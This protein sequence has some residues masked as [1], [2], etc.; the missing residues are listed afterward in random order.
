MARQ[1]TTPVQ[2]RRSIRTDQGAIMSSARAGRVVPVA[3]M[4]L[5]RG[6]SAS[7]RIGIDVELAEMPKPVL[8]AVQVHFQA[9]VVGKQALPRF[10][11]ET[12]LMH[13]YTGEP[14]KQL[15]SA[16][17]T[18]PPWFHVI[19]GVDDVAEVDAS[20]FFRTLGV[21]IGDK[22]VNTDLLDS[23][24]SVYNFRLAAHSSKLPLR[25]YAQVDLTAALELPPAFWPTS[26]LTRYVPDYER[27]LV[28]GAL[29]LDIAA[30]TIP[31]TGFVPV[32]GL[33]QTSN[34]TSGS[35]TA[36]GFD[37][38]ASD[39]SVGNSYTA[40]DPA[41]VVFKRLPGN[42]SGVAL[43]IGGDF[44]SD[45]DDN[46]AV[47]DMSG[48][49]ITSTL[50]DIDKA[51]D[52]QAFARLRS[53]MAGADT[54]G[55]NN[56]DAIVA[57]MMQGLRVP[58][59]DRRRPFLLDSAIVGVNYIERLATDGASLDKSMTTGR[60][61]AVLSLNVPV[62]ED[63]GYIIVTAEMLPERVD[64]RQSDEAL[65][66]TDV[67]QLP[68]ALRDV[69]RPEPVDLVYNRRRD[70]RHTTPDGLY[71]YEPMNDVW[72]RQFTRLGGSY[73]QADPE[74]DWSEARAQL[75]LAGVVDPAFT[76]DH[77]LAPEDFP[78]DV[79]ADTEADAFDFTARWSLSISGLTQIGDVLVE[80][81]GDVAAIQEVQ[82]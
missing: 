33:S 63:G 51:R 75:W 54:T 82:E 12:E 79:F 17:R 30:G 76:A 69:L 52:L 70:A 59:A 46:T 27:A 80:D 60:A 71:G 23:F 42:P 64:E 62:M 37:T 18:P 74:A 77:W 57:T 21:H 31:L 55:Y 48:V 81:N 7:G 24:V 72:N 22:S 19:D 56:D 20:P 50:A 3:Y 43:D 10:S 15:G 9:W 28:V 14:I 41:K 25:D 45:R 65:Y 39:L 35:G 1:S 2:F 16:D 40:G 47:A 36:F 11:G 44:D 34:R 5:L 66:L 32:S 73:Y 6:D 26:R 4:P 13:S 29:D 49:V 53:T 58:E 68:N 38:V 8:N 61:S 67:D 78:H